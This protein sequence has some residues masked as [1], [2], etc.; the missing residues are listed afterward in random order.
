MEP[1]AKARNTK[2]SERHSSAQRALEL[3]ASIKRKFDFTSGEATVRVGKTYIAVMTHTGLVV[4]TDEEGGGPRVLDNRTRSVIVFH[5]EANDAVA[6]RCSDSALSQPRTVIIDSSED[7]R[8]LE[9]HLQ[10]IVEKG[11]ALCGGFVVSAEVEARLRPTDAAV[12]SRNVLG[13]AVAHAHK[14]S[15]MITD[16]DGGTH[17]CA[18]GQ[19]LKKL[20]LKRKVSSRVAEFQSLKRKVTR[21]HAHNESL[22]MELS[23]FNNPD[24][25]PDGVK[26]IFS[27]WTQLLLRNLPEA[28][29][30]L[31]DKL[32]KPGLVQL[33]INQLRNDGK[34]EKGR[35]YSPLTVRIGMALAESND[36][37]YQI[38]RETLGL[39][40]KRV[41]LDMRRRERGDTGFVKGG[42]TLQSSMIAARRR[43]YE[44][45]H[46]GQIPSGSACFDEVSCVLGVGFSSRTDQ[47]YGI[48]TDVDESEFPSL[49]DVF[50]VAKAGGKTNV[51]TAKTILA[52]YWH[53]M[54][55]GH[56]LSGPFAKLEQQ[57]D[58]DYMSTFIEKA[59]DA[60]VGGGFDVEVAV[61]DACTINQSAVKILNGIRAMRGAAAP[62]GGQPLSQFEE[63]GARS[64]EGPAIEK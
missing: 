37:V 51:N 53:D 64:A 14:C 35:R 54:N 27:G 5:D 33:V 4:Q 26:K 36:K 3:I 61:C 25:H 8:A 24:A 44:K 41:I 31:E 11:V 15:G 6:Y 30:L 9:Q 10:T 38:M 39:P 48:L 7:V 50:D 23:A 49:K 19:R 63:S 34:H 18:A 40:S 21:L 57:L 58:G 29:S 22:K 43:E 20:I 60:F 52:S 16:A 28:T 59:V 1:T 17:T 32:Q 42:I 13:G 45:A 47:V 55:S 12:S 62:V 56:S 2:A 46:P